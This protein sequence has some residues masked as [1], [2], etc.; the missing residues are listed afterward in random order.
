MSESV[1]H[2]L[3]PK[4]FI[5]SDLQFRSLIHFKFIFVYDDRKCS[6]FIV[7][8]VVDQFSQLYLLETVF[9]PWYIFHFFV[10]D[11]M[12]IDAWTQIDGEKYHV[13]GLEESI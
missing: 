13:C 7:L 11:K 9:S 6:S 8:H 12:S 10:K 4:G 1:L 2:K 5:V 3:F